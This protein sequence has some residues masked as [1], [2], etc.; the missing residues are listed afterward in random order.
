MTAFASVAGCFDVQKSA[1]VGNLE[2]CEP[3]Q[4]RLEGRDDA[5]AFEK[6]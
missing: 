6:E 1:L 5:Q 2:T 4:P 3:V